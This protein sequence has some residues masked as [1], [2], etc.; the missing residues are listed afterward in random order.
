MCRYGV[1]FMKI[2]EPQSFTYKNGDQAVLLLH[3]FT[4]STAGLKGLG[5]YLQKHGYTVHAPLYQGHGLDPK[6]LIRT[7]PKDW[8]EDV[9]VGYDFLRNEGFENVATVGISLGAIFALNLA[10]EEP[11]NG[12]VSISAPLKNKT[13]RALQ[14]RVL[15]YAENYKRMQGKQAAHI[16]REIERLKD[17]HIPALKDIQQLISDTRKKIQQLRTPIFIMQGV[18][19]EQLYH[20]SADF[21]YHT[22]NTTQKQLKWYE[23]SGHVPTKGP[24]RQ[25]L[26]EDILEFLNTLDW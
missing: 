20:D 6:N 15:N 16:D 8:W 12:I 25:Q 4:G 13:P 3:G 9:R 23:K 18:L 11:V 24:E 7:G 26:N 1:I 21:L 10:F 22:V 19:D 14:E 2:I 17:I 5:R